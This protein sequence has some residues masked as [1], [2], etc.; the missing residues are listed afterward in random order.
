MTLV[1]ELEKNK[2]KEKVSILLD[3]LDKRTYVCMPILWT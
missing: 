2:G 1:L 3:I